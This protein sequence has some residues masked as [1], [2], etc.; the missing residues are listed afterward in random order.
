[1][2]KLKTYLLKTI[3][4]VFMPVLALAN[5]LPLSRLSPL[6]NSIVEV[7]DTDGLRG[8]QALVALLGRYGFSLSEDTM[9]RVRTHMAL[10][11]PYILRS[12]RGAPRIDGRLHDA[13]RHWAR[14]AARDSMC[15]ILGSRLAQFDTQQN[16]RNS[17]S[18]TVRDLGDLVL[19]AEILSDY[20]DAKAIDGISHARQLI[21]DLDDDVRYPLHAAESPAWYLE[22]ALRRIEDPTSAAVLM[23]RDPYVGL[24]RVCRSAADVVSFRVTAESGSEATWHEVP[25]NPVRDGRIL[26]HLGSSR[27]V[28]RSMGGMF[29]NTRWACLQIIFRDGSKATIDLTTL[30]MHYTENTRYSSTGH[31]LECDDLVRDI[32]G[33]VGMYEDLVDL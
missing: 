7:I 15:A 16:D 11:E 13:F 21:A 33:I 14:P 9:Q 17:P 10:L 8:G 2:I 23:R 29:P 6:E 32:W 24:F 5:P 26:A 25:P 28:A 22:M 1:M 4:L 31:W 20:R 18:L 19:C 27:S 3:A 30:G 12:Q